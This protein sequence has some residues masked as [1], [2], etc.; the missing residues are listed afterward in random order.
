MTGTSPAVRPHRT[1]AP[2]GDRQKA[3]RELGTVVAR[4][5]RASRDVFSNPV[6][7]L[8]ATGAPG[9]YLSALAF[10]LATHDAMRAP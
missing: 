7:R 2:H 4:V 6:L 3:L 1:A 5:R 8:I 9:P 10:A